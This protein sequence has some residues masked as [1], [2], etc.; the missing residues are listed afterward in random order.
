MSSEVLWDRVREPVEYSQAVELIQRYAAGVKDGSMQ[1]RVMLL[2]HQEVYTSPK[3]LDVGAIYGIKLQPTNRGGD[4][5]YH[6][7]G[8]RLI[9]P[10]LDL[11]RYKMDLHWYVSAL[12]NWVAA[13]LQKLNI[14][15]FRKELS[16]GI[17]LEHNSQIAK[18]GFV[19][20]RIQSWITLHGCAVNISNSIKYFS[21]I[22]PCGIE[23]CKV[24]SCREAG[25]CVSL[26]EFD[27]SLI[28]SFNSFF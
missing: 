15:A 3:A 18:I 23:N 13:A 19:G 9:Y 26:E 27:L 20:I 6:G 2:E 12:E 25:H 22:K 5:T 7:P 11:R 4:I 28:E 21:H 24:T 1:Q 17:W 10:I 8:Q 14:P 16:R